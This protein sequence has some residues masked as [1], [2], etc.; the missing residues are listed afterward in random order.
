MFDVIGTVT[1]RVMAVNQTELDF[2]NNAKTV[3]WGSSGALVSAVDLP[4]V[5]PVTMLLVPGVT[6]ILNIKNLTPSA[7]NWIDIKSRF[8]T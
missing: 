8:Y 5:S 2:T 6:Y 3:N 4:L 7:I 1:D